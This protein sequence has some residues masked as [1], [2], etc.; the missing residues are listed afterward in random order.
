MD[1][2]MKFSIANFQFKMKPLNKDVC[3]SIEFG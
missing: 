1:F 2:N 3:E